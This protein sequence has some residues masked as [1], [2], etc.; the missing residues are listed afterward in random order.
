MGNC[1][2]GIVQLYDI[3]TKPGE[4]CC[5]W[6][7]LLKSA[8]K[9]LVKN[10]MSAV[11]RSSGVQTSLECLP[12][13]TSISYTPDNVPYTGGTGKSHHIRSVSCQRLPIMIHV[14]IVEINWLRLRILPSDNWICSHG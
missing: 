13:S 1:I 6:F 11:P 7:V 8:H 3:V 10:V 12:H 9:E 5:K 4:V 2:V 14:I